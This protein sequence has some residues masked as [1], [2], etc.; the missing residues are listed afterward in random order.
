MVQR[1]AGAAALAMA[2]R[3]PG[4]AQVSPAAP[5][6]MPLNPSPIRDTSAIAKEAQS[7]L[8]DLIKIKDPKSTRL[9]SS[10]RQISYALLCLKKKADTRHR[11][12]AQHTPG[13]VTTNRI[14]VR[15]LSPRSDPSKAYHTH[16]LQFHLVAHCHPH[17]SHHH[18]E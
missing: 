13:P 2:A 8:A 3:I 7:W 5:P 4:A 18:T 12:T 11:V 16:D 6:G 17:R 9:N 1:M 15:R 14:D 10:H